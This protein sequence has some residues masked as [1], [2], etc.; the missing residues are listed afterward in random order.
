MFS[1]RVPLASKWIRYGMILVVAIG[2]ILLSISHGNPTTTLECGR[3]MICINFSP[4]G[5]TLDKWLHGIGYAL[6]TATLAYAF[7]DSTRI[8]RRNR[9]VLAVCIAVV[10]GGIMEL[11]QWPT[12]QRTMSGL[13]AVANTIGACLVAVLWWKMKG[14][15]RFGES[16][17]DASQIP[18]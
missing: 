7:E 15:V 4:L 10:F 13:D 8:S 5:I 6:L 18:G 1:V 11:V 17:S 16:N 2:D 12:P 14:I 3:G 9:L